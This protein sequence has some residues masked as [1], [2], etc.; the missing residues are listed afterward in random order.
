MNTV[1]KLEASEEAIPS[2]TVSME[3]LPPNENEDSPINSKPLGEDTEDEDIDLDEGN[4][5][6]L[7]EKASTSKSTNTLVSYPKVPEPENTHF[8]FYFLT[9]V[10]LF[11][12]GYVLYQKRGRVFA[13]VRRRNSRRRASRDSRRSGSY[14]K[15]MNNLEE[16]M[17]SSHSVENSNVIY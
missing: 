5:P 14:K 12:T 8:L 7:P 4:A 9:F 6:N 16:A 15:L 13:L 17:T 1:E 11:A 10:V 3:D 2:Y